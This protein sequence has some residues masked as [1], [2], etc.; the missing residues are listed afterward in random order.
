MILDGHQIEG[1]WHKDRVRNAEGRH[2]FILAVGAYMSCDWLHGPRSCGRRFFYDFE[3]SSV[4]P[5][6]VRDT[7]TQRCLDNEPGILDDNQRVGRPG[8][9]LE[10]PSQ[11]DLMPG[12]L[13]E[14]RRTCETVPKFVV[15]SSVFVPNPVYAREDRA[16]SRLQRA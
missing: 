15:T 10:G 13:V 6:F 7:R 1:S 14:Q 8:L 12:G 9:L 3:C 5:F 2:P 11:L 4:C 16:G